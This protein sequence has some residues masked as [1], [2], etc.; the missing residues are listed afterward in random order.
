MN[1]QQP[2]S[3]YG[4]N[5]Q[6]NFNNNYNGE[7]YLLKN[8]HKANIS[9]VSKVCGA[10]VTAFIV[11]GTILGLALSQV[12]G[13]EELYK[14]N[15]YFVS[16]LTA[17]MSLFTLGLPFLIAYKSLKKKNYV[18]DLPLGRP[19]DNKEFALLIPITVMICIF[20]SIAT[21][22]FSTFCEAVFGIEFSQPDDG[23]TYSTFQ[24]VAISFFVTAVIPAFVEEFAIRGVVMQSL[25]KY[26]DGFA[27]IMSSFVFALMHGNMIQIP[28]A[29]IAGIGIGYAVIKTGTMWTGIIIH[30]INN[31]IAVISMTVSQN[32]SDEITN[33]FSMILYTVVFA[34]GIICF[35][36]YANDRKQKALGGAFSKNTLSRGCTSALTSG[37]KAI[38]F[39]FSAPMVI[40]EVLLI[41]ETSLYIN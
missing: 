3:P 19:Y 28:F 41:V 14:N 6:Y 1:Y 34:V 10:A 40:A 30:F 16:A 22:M 2:F 15:E 24:T 27:I 31:A 39:I 9:T 32:C 17:L 12:E 26:G 7:Y 13:F 29:F 35:A 5:S 18:N 33:M 23:S 38:S 4:Q 20:G 8:K 36:L 25:R 21:G 11:L 37:E